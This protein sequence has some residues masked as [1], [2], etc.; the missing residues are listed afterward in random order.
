MN[1]VLTQH[2]IEISVG[3][4]QETHNYNTACFGEV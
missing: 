3:K 4:H 1:L 2:R